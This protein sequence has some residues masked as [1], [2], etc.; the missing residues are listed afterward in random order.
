MAEPISS[1]QQ[2]LKQLW[3]APKPGDVWV[4]LEREAAGRAE[5][6]AAELRRESEAVAIAKRQR[7]RA[8]L[9]FFLTPT[10]F[11]IRDTEFGDW[12][13]LDLCLLVTTASPPCFRKMTSSP[14]MPCGRD[15]LS[16]SAPVR[17][18]WE[19]TDL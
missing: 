8:C 15:L 6:I 9:S 13:S 1:R 18:Q 5:D 17:Q 16:S 3:D 12:E 2:V 4:I 19:G 10:I 14:C 7:L 11:S